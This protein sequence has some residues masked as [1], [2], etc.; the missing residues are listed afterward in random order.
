MSKTACREL[1]LFKANLGPVSMTV[2]ASLAMELPFSSGRAGQELASD[3]A[4]V[5]ESSAACSPLSSP[6]GTEHFSSYS[7]AHQCISPAPSPVT[8][9]TCCTENL[10]LT[11]RGCAEKA[12]LVHSI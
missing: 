3:G 1:L 8:H 6:M 2:E 11:E 9:A 10:H 5:G 7:S 12:G 4:M